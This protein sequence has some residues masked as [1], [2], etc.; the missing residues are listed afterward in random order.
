MICERKIELAEEERER[1]LQGGRQEHKAKCEERDGPKAERGWKGE[2][3]KSE[4]ER[5]PSHS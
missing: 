1:E 4:G 3:I 2:G 5:E